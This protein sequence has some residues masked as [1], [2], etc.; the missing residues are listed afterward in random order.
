MAS[1]SVTRLHRTNFSRDCFN[2][3]GR[4]FTQYMHFYIRLFTPTTVPVLQSETLRWRFDRQSAPVR[5]SIVKACTPPGTRCCLENLSTAP[6]AALA[7]RTHRNRLEFPLTPPVPTSGDRS[8]RICPYALLGTDKDQRLGLIPREHLSGAITM[9]GKLAQDTEGPSSSS[10]HS[11]RS[12]THKKRPTH[13][14]CQTL[15]SSRYTFGNCHDFP[16]HVPSP[17]TEPR[18]ASSFTGAPA[19]SRVRG[20]RGSGPGCFFRMTRACLE[21]NRRLSEH[22]PGHT[23]DR[24]QMPGWSKF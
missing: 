13:D 2:F 19:S 12:L 18:G 6:A 5:S 22:F 11:P 20:A 14:L 23:C 1:S 3:S 16:R 7:R 21:G 9:D 4:G 10:T 15:S 24:H 17:A 8:Q